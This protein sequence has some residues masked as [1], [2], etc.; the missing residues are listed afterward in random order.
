MERSNLCV[1]VAILSLDPTGMYS[2]F[3]MSKVSLFSNAHVM[4]QLRDAAS[5]ESHIS[6]V[7]VHSYS[8]MVS[9][10]TKIVLYKSEIG[11]AQV[12]SPVK[13]HILKRLSRRVLR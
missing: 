12:S 7:R 11:V 9:Y 10:I 1:K 8:S 3:R 2:V 5:R 4:L 6:I 13:L